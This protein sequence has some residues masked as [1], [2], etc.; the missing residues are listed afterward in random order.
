MSKQDQTNNKAKQ[1]STPK[2]VTFSKKNE[3]PRVGFEPTYFLT[4][5]RSSNSPRCLEGSLSTT[6]ILQPFLAPVEPRVAE[7]R[8][9]TLDRALYTTELLPRHLRCTCR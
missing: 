2:V 8:H 4:C 5:E 7:S 9:S 6:L 3:L 1:H